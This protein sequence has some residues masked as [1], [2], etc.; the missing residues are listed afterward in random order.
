MCLLWRAEMYSSSNS[1]L[2]VHLSGF[3][4]LFS[5]QGRLQDICGHFERT[6]HS[7]PLQDMFYHPAKQIAKHIT[8]HANVFSYTALKRMRT[9]CTYSTS[10]VVCLATDTLGSVGCERNRINMTF[11]VLKV[12]FWFKSSLTCL[13]FKASLLV[14]TFWTQRQFKVFYI[15]INIQNRN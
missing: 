1:M 3:T 14:S 10:G 8:T 13:T 9:C 7:C 5:C 4:H 11:G 2:S 6:L 15:S 12:M